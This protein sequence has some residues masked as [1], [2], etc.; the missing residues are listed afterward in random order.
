MFSWCTDYLLKS[1]TTRR[2]SRIQVTTTLN[3]PLKYAQYYYTVHHCIL[4]F[5]RHLNVN[6]KFCFIT[7]SRTMLLLYSAPKE[8]CQKQGICVLNTGYIRLETKTIVLSAI[9]K[10]GVLKTKN[11]IFC[12]MSGEEGIFAIN[13]HRWE[14]FKPFIYVTHLWI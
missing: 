2:L 4:M 9:L 11:A 3:K 12:G 10:N 5:S 1:Q 6:T 8:V 14:S 13:A 7:S